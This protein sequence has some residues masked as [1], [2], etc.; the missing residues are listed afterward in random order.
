[1]GIEISNPDSVYKYGSRPFMEI[2]GWK[3]GP[4]YWSLHQ[5]ANL[6]QLLE[7]DG[8]LEE[9]FPEDISLTLQFKTRRTYLEPRNYDTGEFFDM[10]SLWNVVEAVQIMNGKVEN[11][12]EIKEYINNR[13]AENGGFD[14]MLGEGTNP[15]KA[16][17]HLIVTHDAVMALSTL[18]FDIPNKKQLI[19]WIQT[20]QTSEGG[21]R[22]SPDNESTS[23]QA[24]VWYT[25]AAVRLL[26][27]LGEKPKNYQ[28]CLNWLNSLQNIDGGFGDRPG[29]NSRIYSTYYAVH[30]IQ[31]LT[32]NV[33]SGIEK[34][35][36][37]FKKKEIPEGLYS[38]FQ[39]Q[40][41]TPSGGTEMVDS[42]AAMKFNFIGVKTTEKEVLDG[43]GLSETVSKAREYARQKGY[44]LEI[45]DCPEN[46][47]HR[48]VWFSGMNGDH[49]SN[50][51][52]P[53]SMTDSQNQDYLNLYDEGLKRLP[54]EE[55][56]EKVIKPAEEMGTLFYPELDFTMMNAYMV[57]D[58]GLDGK[59]GYN[60][61]PGA[62]FNNIDWVRHF[63]YKERWL[64]HLP[65]IAD[66]DAHGD[67]VKWIPNLEM[68][69]NVFIAKDY[70]FEDYV[71]AS[72]NGRSVCVI[73][74]PESGEI[75]YYGSQEAVTYLK[76]H[77]EEWKWW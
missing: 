55:F 10:A 24:D 1:M 28:A 26:K 16:K 41:K 4:W 32:G 15:D 58:E 43:K 39:A 34:K 33:K 68:F 38:I 2:E 77:L 12:G 73:K 72:R 9:N 75:R 53:P 31:M 54:W 6:Y 5:K 35:K 42:I 56:R 59:V 66:G 30:A 62:H 47:A 57:Y 44:Q 36:V 11:A 22:W 51:L 27:I 65:M 13:Q 74:M 61:V 17:T 46:Y 14:D 45:V 20:C 19:N 60:A 48:L 25:F 52:I 69:R 40:H 50:M 18:G 76:I 23:N 37:Q 21:F 3:N 67:I 71:D 70:K 7:M 63:P 64:G 29:W 49:C 8:P